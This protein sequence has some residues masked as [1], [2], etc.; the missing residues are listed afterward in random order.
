M[1]L[2]DSDDDVEALVGSFDD[3][4]E[5]QH[6]PAELPDLAADLGDL[7]AVL[8]DL[9]AGC[10]I[11][12]LVCAF[13]A[14]FRRLSSESSALRAA[15]SSGPGNDPARSDFSFSLPGVHGQLRGS[16][17]YRQP[18]EQHPVSPWRRQ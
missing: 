14:L 9:A 2:D 18:A 6:M 12:L 7:V 15:I 16:R 1:T 4:S 3:V 5:V 11:R 17:R 8:G 13:R 10:A